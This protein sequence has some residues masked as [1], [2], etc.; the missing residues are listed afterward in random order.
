MA[1]RSGRSNLGR[2]STSAVK[3]SCCPSSSWVI[4]RSGWPR[5]RISLSS[6]ALPYSSGTASLI[7]CSSTA[8]RPSRWSMIR[9]G[10]WPGRNP[11]IR[12]C[13]LTS[14]YA[15]SR[16]GFSSSKGTSMVSLTRVGLSSSTSVF[17]AASL[18]GRLRG[19]SAVVSAAHAPAVRRRPRVSQLWRA[20][21][22]A[23]RGPRQAT[24]PRLTGAGRSVLAPVH[25]HREE[26]EHHDDADLP[27]HDLRAASA[28]G[29]PVISPR[30]AVAR[31]DI[32]LTRTNAC[33]LRRTHPV[34]L[35][36]SALR[37]GNDYAPNA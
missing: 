1:D 32:G 20:K 17:T 9:G 5:A 34:R 31:S 37:P 36:R 10:T 33:S 22:R 6:S 13:L 15:L 12:T 14:R 23:S 26:R 25:A 2:T 19:T 35:E 7:A 29:P 4:S 30:V 3:A 16:L 28:T 11:G 8:P 18:P 24:L 27:Q 21:S